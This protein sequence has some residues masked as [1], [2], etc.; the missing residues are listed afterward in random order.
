MVGGV[1]SQNGSLVTTTT[2]NIMYVEVDIEKTILQDVGKL[3]ANTRVEI[4]YI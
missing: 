1:S 4:P 2:Y 3:T